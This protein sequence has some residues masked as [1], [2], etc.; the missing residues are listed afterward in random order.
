M[1]DISCFDLSISSDGQSIACR[2]DWGKIYLINTSG[3]ILWSTQERNQGGGMSFSADGNHLVYSISSL[4]H[5]F[6]RQKDKH[7]SIDLKTIDKEMNQA[8][9][10]SINRDGSRT[11]VGD[12]VDAYPD[13]IYKFLIFDLNGNVVKKMKIQDNNL[14]Q[15]AISNDGSYIAI[16]FNKKIY[17]T[18]TDGNVLWTYDA[19][20]WGRIKEITI[21]DNSENIIAGDGEGNVYYFENTGRLLWKKNI[22]LSVYDVSVSDDGTVIIACDGYT[23]I[24]MLTSTGEIFVTAIYPNNDP[25]NR[26]IDGFY[27]VDISNSN[28]TYYMVAGGKNGLFLHN[29]SMLLK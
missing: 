20:P 14:N 28:N 7:W 6:D 24:V 29:P 17:F 19:G 12:L 21:S 18:D 15:L 3:G 9:Q 11:I 22:G 2:D 25:N 16:A 13:N 10:V 23:R 5:W 27:T 4:V 1:Q 26:P 8:G